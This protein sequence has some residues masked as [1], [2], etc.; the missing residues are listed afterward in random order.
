LVGGVIGIAGG[1]MGAL[2]SVGGLAS[3]MFGAISSTAGFASIE[4]QIAA[5][6]VKTASLNCVGPLTTITGDLTVSA[7][8]VISLSSGGFINLTSGVQQNINSEIVSINSTS[9]SNLFSAFDVNIAGLTVTIT[10]GDIISLTSVSNINL[11]APNINFI[12][13]VNYLDVFSGINTGLNG[14]FRFNDNG[15]MNQ[16]NDIFGLNA[17]GFNAFGMI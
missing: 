8:L 17:S 12:G 10:G 6:T 4:S 11:I 14:G 1:M 2:S 9:S 3:G 15:S 5:L 16:V 7:P 13:K